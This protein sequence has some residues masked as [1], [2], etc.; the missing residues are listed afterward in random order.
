MIA[1]GIRRSGAT[2]LNPTEGDETI[3]VLRR[4]ARGC[5]MVVTDELRAQLRTALAL[6]DPE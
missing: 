6:T 5:A 2:L 1:P 3:Q 4:Q